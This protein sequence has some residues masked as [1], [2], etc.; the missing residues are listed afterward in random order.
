MLELKG[1]RWIM[2]GNRIAIRH[3]PQLATRALLRLSPELTKWLYVVGLLVLV[4]LLAFVYLAQASIVARQIDEMANLE[5]QIQ[6]IKRQNNE[7]R[8]RVARL[9]DLPLTQTQA[10]ALGFREATKIEYVEVLVDEPAASGG[11]GVGTTAASGA[12]SGKVRS[13]PSGLW[14]DVVQQFQDWIFGGTVRADESS[15]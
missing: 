10:R 1:T 12:G 13:P 9:E 15:R 5:S 3:K 11:P 8:L 7:L 2:T 14:S 4:S 6:A